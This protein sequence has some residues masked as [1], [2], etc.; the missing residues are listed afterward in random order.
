MWVKVLIVLLPK[1]KRMKH[2]YHCFLLIS[3]LLVACNNKYV[4]KGSSPHRIKGGEMAYL[5]VTDGKN[6]SSIDS[7]RIV[8]GRFEMSGEIDSVMCVSFFI[9]NKESFPLVLE[10]GD[11]DIDMSETFIKIGGTPLNDKLY[12]YL[13]QRDSMLLEMEDLYF[14]ERNLL[15][16]GYSIHEARN[17]VTGLRNDILRNIDKLNTNFVIDN[18]D[19]VLGVTWF[20]RMCNEASMRHGYPTTTSQIDQLYN[21]APEEFKANPS[22][23]KFMEQ[24]DEAIFKNAPSPERAVDRNLYNAGFE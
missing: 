12:Q 4:I 23:A 20:L 19:N 14:A 1:M 3:V 6:F 11:I 18:F 16:D 22:I 15:F 17:I 5:K 8:H 2:F 10:Y 7:C 9:D 24:V 21:A 13:H